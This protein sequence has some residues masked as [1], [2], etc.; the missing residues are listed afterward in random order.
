MKGQKMRHLRIKPAETDIIMHI[1]NRICGLSGGFLFGNSE[2]E[3]FTIRIAG[4][5]AKVD[6]LVVASDIFV[7]NTV[8]QA[9]GSMALA[10]RKLTH[11]T[12]SS[13]TQLMLCRFKRL[14]KLVL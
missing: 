14:Q 8:A 4:A 12:D 11:A 6:G 5:D 1:Y 3:L 7:T 2:K 10:K 13:D 9:R